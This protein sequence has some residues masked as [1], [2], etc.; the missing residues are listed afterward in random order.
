MLV[1]LLATVVLHGSV[2]LPG[3]PER[4]IIEQ[5][6][7]EAPINQQDLAKLPVVQEALPE[8]HIT[9]NERRDAFLREQY[10]QDCFWTNTLQYV[11]YSR[12]DSWKRRWKRI[13]RVGYKPQ[14]GYNIAWKSRA[15]LKI[16]VMKAKMYGIEL[17]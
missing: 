2:D 3:S 10:S 7:V 14:M 9:P 13:Q 16:V 4:F 8:L 6:P 17:E 15:E 11:L 1:D 12:T 5:M